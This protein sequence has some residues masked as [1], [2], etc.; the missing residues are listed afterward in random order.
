MAKTVFEQ[1]GITY[2]RQR[3]YEIPVVTLPPEKENYVGIWGQ[4]YRRWLRGNHRVPY[5]NLLTS[6]K[7]NE[8]TAEVDE[9]AENLFFRLV[10]E[11][12][13]R[14]GVTEMLKAAI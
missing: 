13:E 9:R 7:L 5:Y 12:A 6:G 2:V 10:R 1:M 11:M 3:D 8:Q 4:R 14:E